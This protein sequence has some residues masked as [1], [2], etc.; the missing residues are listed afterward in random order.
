VIEPFVTPN[1]RYV[2][3]TLRDD[4]S[5]WNTLNACLAGDEYHLAGRALT[6]VAI[7]IG[8][9]IGGATVA[10]AMDNPGLRVIAVEAVPPN[11]E[12]LRQ[13]VARNGLADRVT[14][15]EGAAGGSDPVDVWYGYRGN[16]TAE[17]HAFIGNSSL[18]YDHGGELAHETAHYE[19]PWSLAQLVELAGGHVDLIKIDCEGAE[20]TIL[21]SNA[22]ASV[23]EVIGEWHGV[24]G[25]SQAD[26]AALL[27]DY[28][29]TFSGPV[30]GPGGFVAVR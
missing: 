30:A 11:A 20:W 7:D 18:A 21:D 13:N 28:R 29:V 19:T 9:H 22:R 27:N 16:E 12:L 14:V 2:T 24:R 26:M 10:L 25:H 1:G 6:G 15:I 8:A 4:T 23:D 3:M 5:D 17:H